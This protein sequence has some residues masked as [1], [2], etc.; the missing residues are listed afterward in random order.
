M[1]LGAIPRGPRF[2]S[3]S[4]HS[5]SAL[6]AIIFYIIHAEKT[7]QVATQIRRGEAVLL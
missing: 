3:Q 4:A 7:L 6:V 5:F 1:T 2:N